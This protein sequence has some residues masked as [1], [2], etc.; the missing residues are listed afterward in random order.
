MRERVTLCGGELSTE[1]GADQRATLIAR[2][3]LA[4]QGALV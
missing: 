4:T 1:I 3:P 2:L